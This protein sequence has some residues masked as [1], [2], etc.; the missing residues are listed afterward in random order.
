MDSG[1]VSNKNLDF[2]SG[3]NLVRGSNE[4][5]KSTFAHFIKAMLYGVNRN[6]AGKAFSDF[7]RF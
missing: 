5:G 2:D 7:E 4:S 3:I 1:N 6:K